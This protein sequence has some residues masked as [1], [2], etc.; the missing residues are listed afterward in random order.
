MMR[1]SAMP[2]P[3]SKRPFSTRSTLSALHPCAVPRFTPHHSASRSRPTFVVSTSAPSSP[4]LPPIHAIPLPPPR[5]K[6]SSPSP[7]LFPFYL[8]SH[9]GHWHRPCAQTYKNRVQRAARGKNRLPWR[10]RDVTLVPQWRLRCEPSGG[11]PW[12]TRARPSSGRFRI[13]HGTTEACVCTARRAARV[14]SSS[15][16]IPRPT[17]LQSREAEMIRGRRHQEKPPALAS[18]NSNK[19]VGIIRIT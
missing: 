9:H 15:L 1:S 5:T 19:L 12:Q 8:H 11:G 13:S 10:T 17:P 3:R 4:S 18:D 2:G 14:P 16:S 7:L 6:R